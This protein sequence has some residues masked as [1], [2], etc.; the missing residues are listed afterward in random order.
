MFELFQ[1]AHPVS[2]AAVAVAVGRFHFS[3]L[4]ALIVGLFDLMVRRLMARRVKRGQER[5]NDHQCQGGFDARQNEAEPA[6]A[7]GLPG[8]KWARK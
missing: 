7:A 5:D 2:I 6:H 3:G 1:R 4:M 8:Y